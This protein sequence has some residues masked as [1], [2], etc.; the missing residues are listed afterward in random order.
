MCVQELISDF[1]FK[2]TREMKKKTRTNIDN[3]YNSSIKE[4]RFNQIEMKRTLEI[5]GLAV[6]VR[7]DKDEIA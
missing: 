2:H 4:T 3:L 7:K 1:Y 5:I 6:F